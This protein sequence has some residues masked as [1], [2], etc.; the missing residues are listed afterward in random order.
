MN[1]L[2]KYEQE[3]AESSINTLAD[4]LDGIKL[5][6]GADLTLNTTIEE[7]RRMRPIMDISALQIHALNRVQI[8]IGFHM[9][10]FDVDAHVTTI[11]TG[12]GFYNLLLLF[13]LPET[14]REWDDLFRVCQ[15]GK[16]GRIGIAGVPSKNESTRLVYGEHSKI[17][18]PLDMATENVGTGEDDEEVILEGASAPHVSYASLSDTTKAFLSSLLDKEIH[19]DYV[20]ELE[21]GVNLLARMDPTF[22]PAT[23]RDFLNVQ[24]NVLWDEIPQAILAGHW[25]LTTIDWQGSPWVDTEMFRLLVK[26]PSAGE[27]NPIVAVFEVSFD[28]EEDCYYMCVNTIGGDDCRL[29]EQRLC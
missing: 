14:H 7:F 16:E 3:Q 8:D 15:S 5:C 9:D 26:I 13:D 20:L 25:G 4:L 19:A 22:L 12:D 2:K 27:A 21:G 28:E 1:P 17:V 6:W 29:M 18:I 24:R 11:R 10:N 23:V